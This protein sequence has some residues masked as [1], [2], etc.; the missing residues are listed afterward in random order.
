MY[1]LYNYTLV[2]NLA[3]RSGRSYIINLRGKF[4]PGPEF[5]PGCPTEDPGSNPGSGENFFS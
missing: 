1:S 2:E 4:S 5:E 3:F